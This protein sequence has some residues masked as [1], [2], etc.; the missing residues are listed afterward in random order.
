[1]IV[2][3]IGRV[4]LSRLEDFP[5]VLFIVRVNNA[6]AAW[7]IMK[8]PTPTIRRIQLEKDRTATS[9]YI[10]TAEVSDEARIFAEAFQST[11][12]AFAPKLIDVCP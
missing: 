8:K 5:S 1:M 3:A 7:I 6:T 9:A 4:R 11:A 10:N 2:L 12:R